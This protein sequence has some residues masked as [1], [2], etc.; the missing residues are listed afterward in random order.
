MKDPVALAYSGRIPEARQA[1]MEQAGS[2]DEFLVVQG[3]EALAVL[4][5]QHG[6]SANAAIDELLARRATESLSVSRKAFDAATSV[7]SRALEEEAAKRL[8]SG[9]GSWEVLR[10]AGEWPS[11]RLARAL[12]TGWSQLPDRLRD[13]ALLT[14]AVMPAANPDEA[15]EYGLLAIEGTRSAE[16]SIR[17]AAFVALKWWV[18]LE[19]ADLCARALND[20]VPGIRTAAAEL[21]SS[22]EPQRLVDLAEELP[23]NAEVQ[24]AKKLAA[25]ELLR[26]ALKQ[27]G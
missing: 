9:R 22:L 21:L 3:L 16:E 19:T 27:N 23:E 24:A 14:I 13:E 15:R 4:G 20:E 26:R 10:Y 7:G 1:A 6:V 5:Q 8:E 2:D 11:H 17:A 18:P 12:F 25:Q